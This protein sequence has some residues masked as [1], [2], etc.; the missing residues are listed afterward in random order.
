MICLF[1]SLMGK[2]RD[3]F[4]I[5]FSRLT[6]TSQSYKMLADRESEL[7]CQSVIDGMKLTSMVWMSGSGD[8]AV[9]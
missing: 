9:V 3:R 2:R 6:V 5:S 4:P 8:F 7:C 1:V